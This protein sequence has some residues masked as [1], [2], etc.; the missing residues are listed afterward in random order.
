L[1]EEVGKFLDGLPV[2]AYSENLYERLVR[3][4]VNNPMAFALVAAYLVMRILFFL[5][6]RR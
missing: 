2:S 3:I 6:F 1:S 4:V 5:F